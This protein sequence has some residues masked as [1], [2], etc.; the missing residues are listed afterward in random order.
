MEK[1]GTRYGFILTDQELVAIRRVQGQD[2]KA[3]KGDLEL[4]LPIPWKSDKALYEPKSRSRSQAP[5]L[6]VALALWYLGMLAAQD[7]NWPLNNS[8]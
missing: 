5:R 1:Y 4:S 8:S 6:T 3:V 7:T 2:G